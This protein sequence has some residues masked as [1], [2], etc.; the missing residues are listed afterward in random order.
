[1]FRDGRGELYDFL[2]EIGRNM[3]DCGGTTPLARFL[4][5]ASGDGWIV[6]HLNELGETDLDLLARSTSKFSVVH[7][8]RSHQYF[9]HSPFQLERLRALGFNICLATDSLASNDDLNL[10]AEMRAFARNF[11]SVSPEEILRMV[12]TNPARALTLNNCAGKICRGSHV[13]LIAVPFSGGDVFEEI[14]GFAGEPWLVA[15]A[16]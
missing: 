16:A 5:V 13:D 10:F 1:M 15:R 2:K 4:E 12:T 9:E 6:A 3:N 11:P 14:V 8:P 7:C